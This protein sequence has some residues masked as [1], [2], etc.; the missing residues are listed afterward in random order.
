VASIAFLGVGLT[1]ILSWK[2]ANRQLRSTHTLK[3]AEMRQE[4]INSLRDAMSKFQSYGV[5]PGVAHMAEREFY[6][7]G[8]RIEL[9]MNPK[10]PEYAELQECLYRFLAAE[11]LKEKYSA[12]PKFVAICQRVLKRE[13]ETLKREITSAG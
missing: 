1:L 8:T 11:D 13:W 12:N 2:N 3:I 7:C 9:L 10:D 4:W 6:E 5:T